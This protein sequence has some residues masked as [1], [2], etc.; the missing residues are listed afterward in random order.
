MH[1]FLDAINKSYTTLD[2][3]FIMLRRAAPI[4]SEELF[5]SNKQLR[6]ESE[7]QK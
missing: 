4:S 5:S 1:E 6:E 2:N 7:A 3:Q